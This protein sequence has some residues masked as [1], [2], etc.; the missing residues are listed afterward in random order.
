MPS[1]RSGASPVSDPEITQAMARLSLMPTTPDQSRL[2][3]AGVGG[4]TLAAL[5][6]ATPGAILCH[7]CGIVLTLCVVAVRAATRI[8]EGHE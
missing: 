1:R 4:S 6:N 7:L 5:M 2:A 8:A 3:F